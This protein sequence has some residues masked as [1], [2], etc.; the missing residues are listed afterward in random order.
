MG[1]HFGVKEGDLYYT[2]KHGLV[3]FDEL[4]DWYG[5]EGIKFQFIN[6]QTDPRIWYKGRDCS[7]Y[8]VEDT[9]WEDY[10]H[11]GGNENGDDFERY[12]QFYADDVKELCETILFPELHE[13][14]T[15]EA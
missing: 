5:I 13:Y 3:Q 6:T 14:A 8:D 1:R 10:L 9:M 4:P 11:D 15:T 12:M 2:L 7:C